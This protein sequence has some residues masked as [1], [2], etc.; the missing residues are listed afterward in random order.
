MKKSSVKSGGANFG[1]TISFD[2]IMEICLLVIVFLIPIIFDRRLGIV[3]SGTKVAWLRCFVVVALGVWS[4]KLIVLREHRFIRTALDWPVVSFL[5][6]TTVATITSVH[7]YTSFTGFYGRFEGLTTWYLFGLLFFITTNFAA[8][9]DRLKRLIIIVVQSGVAMAVYGVIQRQELDPYA[10]GGVI[11]WQ[12]VIGTIGQPNFLAAYILMA[13]FLGLYLFLEEKK[14]VKE[15]D[16]TLQIL[17][18]SY[19]AAA[20]IVFI[21]MLFT[22]QASDVVVWY[23]GFALATAAALLFAFHSDRLQ[24]LV[25]DTLW[26]GALTLIYICLLYTQSRGGY[27]GF[28][29]GAVLFV[30]VAG[31]RWLFRN[32]R[33]LSVLGL[34]IVAISLFTMLRPEYSPFERFAGEIGAKQESAGQGEVTS[35]LELKGAAGSRGE[36]WKS[37]FGVVADNPLFGVGP[38]VLKMVF[39]RY[40]T[41]LFRFKE[42]FH[43]KQDRCHNE[44]FDVPVT[45]GLIS[46]FLYLL[47]IGT[48]F[49]TGWQKLARASDHERLMLAGLLAAI[50]AYL[51]QNQFSFG[52][53]A[54]T[55]LFWVLW[56]M[57]MVAGERREE[58]AAPIVWSELPWLAVAVIALIAAAIISVGFISFRQDIHFKSGKTYMEMRQ[59]PTAAAELQQALR[60]MPF[61]GTTISHLAIVYLNQGD[62]SAALKYLQYGTKVDPLNADNYYMLARVYYSQGNRELAWRNIEIALKIDPYYAEAYETRGQLLQSEGRLREAAEMFERAFYV[63]PTVPGVLHQMEALD[64]Q[65][66]RLVSAR[67]L[68]KDGLDKFPDNLELYKAWE[69]VR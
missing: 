38:E 54:I 32:W 12:R 20:Q 5:L 39:P 28:F 62:T 57:V 45:K 19:F 69:R 53:V 64:R 23:L 22:L 11:T 47:I 29:T 40:E 36:T 35:K 6:T 50:V 25:L 33:E 51:V 55:S 7:V 44:T 59:L 68:I 61:E 67:R 16:W 27:M 49:A 34:V 56:G 48:V 31:R 10:W 13:F 42:A 21:A 60:I 15:T 63:N 18:L 52:V 2:Q 30:V 43:V 46:F 17:P 26:G 3:F 58:K 37:A 14:P 66:G 65:V 41:D 1:T 24:P 4:L 9:A 8:S